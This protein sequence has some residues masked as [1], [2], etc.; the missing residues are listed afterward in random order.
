M[1][2]ESS[3]K[4]IIQKY[5]TM[6]EQKENDPNTDP[7]EL[8]E[9]TSNFISW[10]EEMIKGGVVDGEDQTYTIKHC[11]LKVIETEPE[12]GS[13]S[14]LF[15]ALMLFSDGRLKELFGVQIFE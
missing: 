1:D 3:I 6:I 13:H 5:T 14:K 7:K 15:D 11:I 9:Q 10:F 2:C 4:L 12:D 8:A